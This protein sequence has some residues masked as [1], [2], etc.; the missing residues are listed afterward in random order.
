MFVDNLHSVQSMAAT[1]NHFLRFV[2][3]YSH[4]E[5]SSSVN[6]L[7]ELIRLGS[8][9][10]VLEYCAVRVNWMA[11]RRIDIT[12]ETRVGDPTSRVV[13]TDLLIKKVPGDTYPDYMAPDSRYG[14]MRFP[15]R[16]EKD[17]LA[18]PLPPGMR[19]P[20]RIPERRMVALGSEKTHPWKGR[21]HGV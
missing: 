21:H 10:M 17:T 6:R 5:N 19:C 13:V 18:E 2:S 12:T 3:R 16:R 15:Y 14:P 11:Q 7:V 9:Y 4:S 20:V 1:S 8:H